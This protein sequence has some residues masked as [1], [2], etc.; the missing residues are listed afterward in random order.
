MLIL[1]NSF[2]LGGL[3]RKIWSLNILFCLKEE[4]WVGGRLGKIDDS[5][6]RNV[7]GTVRAS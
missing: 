4:E 5:T 3:L 1:E 2:E 7:T 6:S